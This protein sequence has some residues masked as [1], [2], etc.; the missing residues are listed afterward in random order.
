MT[1]HGGSTGADGVVYDLDGTLVRLQVDWAQVASDVHDVYESAGIEP[2]SSELWDLMNYADDHGI[3]DPVEE[4]VASHERAGARVAAEL[5][6][7]A[8]LRDEDRPVAVCSLNCETACRIALQTHGLDGDVRA[9]IGRD[10][11]TKQKPAAEPLLAAFD[12][13]DIDPS[14]G[15]FIGDSESD[16]TTAERAGSP[17]RYVSDLVDRV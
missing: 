17:F 8:R 9:V 2:S 11:V 15:L 13:I 6:I 4:A 14:A 10:T 3:G 16:A 5:P 7:A 1:S 12:A